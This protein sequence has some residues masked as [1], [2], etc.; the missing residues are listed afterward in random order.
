MD[1]GTIDYST[2]SGVEDDS[3]C[4]RCGEELVGPTEIEI[5]SINNCHGFDDKYLQLRVN[6][7]KV[8]GTTST[9]S[10]NISVGFDLDDEV[11][12]N[13]IGNSIT[14][15][16]S[17]KKKT[18]I[19]RKGFCKLFDNYIYARTE[20]TGRESFK[21]FC[22]IYPGFYRMTDII[23]KFGH[24]ELPYELLG[25]KIYRIELTRDGKVMVC[26]EFDVRCTRR[27]MDLSESNGYNK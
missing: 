17:L 3:D 13:V 8:A 18:Y 1:S 22:P 7:N 23:S 9:I 10:G 26:K 24:L 21:S 4:R 25:H 19:S 16:G 14:E 2:T 27:D 12:I 6:V 20:L 15:N 11:K 5:L